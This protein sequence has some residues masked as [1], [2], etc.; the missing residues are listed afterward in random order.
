MKRKEWPVD[1]VSRH[2]QACSGPIFQYTNGIARAAWRVTDHY[3]NHQSDQQSESS[4]HDHR[5]SGSLEWATLLVAVL[6]PSTSPGFYLGGG[7]DIQMRVKWSCL[8]GGYNNHRYLARPLSALISCGR[9]MVTRRGW[10]S[11]EIFFGA[12]STEDIN[13]SSMKK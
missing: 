6:T 5:R 2:R 13:T 11:L 9:V 3:S 7:S 8:E 4:I 12:V 1:A 10:I